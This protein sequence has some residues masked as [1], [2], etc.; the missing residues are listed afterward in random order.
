MVALSNCIFVV[1]KEPGVDTVTTFTTTELDEEEHPDG[2]VIV[3]LYVPATDTL[4][5]EDV[6]P[7]ITPLASLHS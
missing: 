1:V 3:K 5:V 6:A 2:V 4:Y 7:D